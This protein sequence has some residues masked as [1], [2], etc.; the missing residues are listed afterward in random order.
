MKTFPKLGQPA[1]AFDYL[2]AEQG[3]KSLSAE[4]FFSHLIGPISIL[5]LI[6]VFFSLF[7]FFVL[8]MYPPLRIYMILPRMRAY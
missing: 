3:F 6:Q 2:H 8:V 1:G 4:L 7:G 5:K